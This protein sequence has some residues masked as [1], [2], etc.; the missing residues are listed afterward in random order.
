MISKLTE[1]QQNYIEVIYEL[2]KEHSHA[3]VKSI[4]DKLHVSMPTVSEALHLLKEMNLVNHKFRHPVTLTAKGRKIAETLDKRHREFFLFL[5][6]ILG[7]NNDYAEK[8]ACKLE[9]FID[10]DL[11][12]R[13]HEFQ[14][15]LRNYVKTSQVDIISNFI[16]STTEK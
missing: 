7:F 10:D 3:H 15:Y 4:A 13:I 11:R 8:M 2:S 14:K 16:K 5:T 6:Q 9:H 12:I 1:S